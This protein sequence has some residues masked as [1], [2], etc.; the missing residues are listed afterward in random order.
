MISIAGEIHE[1]GAMSNGQL[2]DRVDRIAANTCKYYKYRRV[3]YNY[4]RK[5]VY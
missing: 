3:N 2:D 1:G 4:Q 5:W